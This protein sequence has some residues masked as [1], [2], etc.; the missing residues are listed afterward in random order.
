MCKVDQ[1]LGGDPA[2]LS[3]TSNSEIRRSFR[4]LEDSGLVRIHLG[5]NGGFT[6]AVIRWTKRAIVSLPRSVA[7]FSSTANAVAPPV[8]DAFFN[9]YY[10]RHPDD[11]RRGYVTFS[12]LQRLR[13][14]G[15]IEHV[16][17]V[18]YDGNDCEVHHVED[19]KLTD[20]GR[21]AAIDL[22]QIPGRRHVRSAE[23]DAAGKAPRGA[24]P[25]AHGKGRDGTDVQRG[26]IRGRQ[27][28]FPGAGASL[29]T[30]YASSLSSDIPDAVMA[31][32]MPHLEQFVDVDGQESLPITEDGIAATAKQG[33]LSFSGFSRY[34]KGEVTGA[35]QVW[36]A[37]VTASR[38]CAG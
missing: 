32:L 35:F 12:N 24:P 22:P 17:N 36:D 34:E 1:R 13:D 16:A 29:A 8:P 6:K 38:V 18:P 14:A 9:H 3:M 19:W 28:M 31:L 26:R 5:P 23:G 7:G 11:G 37:H 10:I 15:L 2:L 20:A 33:P 25:P 4:A 30:P 27:V 21:A